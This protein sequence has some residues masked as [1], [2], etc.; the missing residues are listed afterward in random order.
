MAKT[1][2]AAKTKGGAGTPKSVIQMAKEKGAQFVDIKFVDLPGIWQHFAI[3][4][5]DALKVAQQ[6]VSQQEVGPPIGA[7]AWLGVEVKEITR[8]MA[9]SYGWRVKSGLLV[10]SVNDP[11]P[12]ANAGIKKSDVISEAD[13]TQIKGVSDL[14]TVLGRHRSG[15]TI[16]LIVWA[17]GQNKR[18]VKVTLEPPP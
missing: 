2:R 4:I 3:P 17:L 13:G 5:N 7:P 1:T 14:K 18:T 6:L 12:A 15:D 10:K 11:G 8:D 9:D 16:S